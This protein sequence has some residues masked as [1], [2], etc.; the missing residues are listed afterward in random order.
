MTFSS[1]LRAAFLLS[2]A[3][4]APAMPAMAQQ[5]AATPA[6]A[7]LHAKLHQLFAD[8]DEASLKRNPIMALFRGDLRYADR[9]GDFVSDTYFAAERAAGEDDLRRLH[10][11]DRAKLNAT[12]QLAYD[13]FEWQ[14]ELG[15]K[16]LTPEMLALTAVRPIDHFTGFH[17][18]YPGFASGKGAA[19]FKTLADYKNNLKRHKEYVILLDRAIG[20]FREGMASGVVQS[21]MT[22]NNMVGQLDNIINQGVEQSTF[23]GPVEKFP[24]GISAADQ[25]RLKA[26]YA[27][28]IK[29][30]LIP[31]HTLQRDFLKNEYLPVARETVGISTMKGGDI[32]YRAA[33]EEKTTLPLT[34]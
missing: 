3:A 4:L 8:S 5:P 9:L 18:F 15:L 10:A 34:A 11:I 31:A 6:A 27:A 20:R 22:V 13:V 24:E 28:G 23:Y 7:D 1:T 21:K 29:N 12:D 2:V 17:T 19:P 14:T 25:A 33:I 32:V 26:E 30:D 16:N